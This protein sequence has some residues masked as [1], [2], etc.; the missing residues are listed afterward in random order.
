MTTPVH[1]VLNRKLNRAEILTAP[2][3]Q[4]WEMVEASFRVGFRMS[5]GNSA[6]GIGRCRSRADFDKKAAHGGT[7]V[8]NQKEVA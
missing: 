7:L 6:D 3:F 5:D 4:D 1:F 8:L 2:M